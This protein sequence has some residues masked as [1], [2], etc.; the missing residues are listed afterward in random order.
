MICP[1]CT[2]NTAGQ[3]EANCPN[4]PQYILKQV[5][6]AEAQRVIP[7]VSYC[8]THNTYPLPNEPCWQCANPYIGMGVSSEANE[9]L[10]QL[11]ADATELYRVLRSTIEQ[12]KHGGGWNDYDLRRAEETARRNNWIGDAI[13]TPRK[14]VAQVSYDSRT[15]ESVSQALLEIAPILAAQLEGAKKITFMEAGWSVK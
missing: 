13:E 11:H 7:R 14:L 5:R 6:E 9:L 2:L 1:Y 15:V 8:A 10:R 4:N 3:H 12:L